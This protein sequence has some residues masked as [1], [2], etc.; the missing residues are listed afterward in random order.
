MPPRL[1]ADTVRRRFSRYGFTILDP[2]FIYRNAKQ[3]VRVRDDIT[4]RTEEVSI[5]ALQKRIKRGRVVE[6][7]PFLHALHRTDTLTLT[8]PGR[9]QQSRLDRKIRRFAQTQIPQFLEEDRSIQRL[10]VETADRLKSV[11]SRGRNVSI[12]R[13]DDP[14][15]DRAQLYAFIDTLYKVAELN[16]REEFRK[17]RISVSVNANGM[18]SFMYINDNTIATLQDLIQHIYFGEPLNEIS[19]SSTAVLFSLVDWSTMSVLFFDDNSRVPNPLDGPFVGSRSAGGPRVDEV[20]SEFIAAGGPEAIGDGDGLRP[21]SADG[22]DV[23]N[24]PRRRTRNVGSLWR[25]LNK[26]DIDLSRYGIFTSFDVTNYRYSCF[27]YALQQSGQFTPEEIDLIND[28][29]NTRAFPCDTISEICRLYDCHI[30]VEKVKHS[31]SSKSAHIKT[32]RYGDASA[33]RRVSLLLRDTH[34]M[35]NEPVPVTEYYLA[36]INR[37]ASSPRVNQSRRFECRNLTD[38]SVNYKKDPRTSLN[39]FLDMMFK[40]RLF[41]RFTPSQSFRALNRDKHHDFTQLDYAPK[42]VRDVDTLPP[43]NV[44]YRDA[45]VMSAAPASFDMSNG[46][47]SPSP[48]PS[49]TLV[50]TTN[51]NSFLRGAQHG[52]FSLPHLH[53]SKHKG[54]IGG[55]G[56]KAITKIAFDNLTV[57]RNARS[58]FMFE[59]TTDEVHL[60]HDLLLTHFDVDF[61]AYDTLA[62]LGEALMYSY[63]CYEDVP[64]LAG[65]PAVFIKQCAPKICIQPAYRKPVHVTGSLVQ[66]DRNGSYTATYTEFEGIPKGAPNVIDPERWSEIK[67]NATYYYV[68]IDVHS[69]SCRHCD[70]RFE[71]VTVGE[72][73]I[74]RNML[75]FIEQHYDIDYTFISGYY[76]DSGFNTNIKRLATDLYRLRQQL[77]RNGQRIES[78][79]KTILSSLWGK[80]QPK[81]RITKEVSVTRD[82]LDDFVVYNKDFLSRSTP[83]TDDVTIFSLLNPVTLHYTRPQFSTNVLSHARTT[84]NSIFYRAADN[85]IPIYYS[86]TDSLVLNTA[87]LDKLNR[88]R[89]GPAGHSRYAGG[90]LVGDDLGQFKRERENICTF[91]CLSPKKYIQRTVGDVDTKIVGLRCKNGHDRSPADVEH[92]FAEWYSSSVSDDRDGRPVDLPGHSPDD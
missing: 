46:A 36:N 1:S 73:F 17:K 14:D 81:R 44:F 10:A 11:V 19:D 71:L 84:L 21:G 28:S 5:D 8:T 59:P 42:C 16:Q 47:L 80:A 57:V 65:K 70:D 37:I 79:I 50:F 86:N 30:I 75:E 92:T 6:V 12:T 74:D 33:S 24:L 35:I 31:I 56:P 49:L 22:D 62:K 55:A 78:C 61:Y 89:D 87:D 40:H 66:I 88:L 48:L 29:I 41:R 90:H 4:N 60:L 72:T 58:T 7:D 64:Q 43:P 3:H 53:I 32:A 51:I 85:D 69:V 82:R 52:V 63:H 68:L 27:V 25:Y 18:E 54:S 20:G 38:K 26:T 77:K 9:R 83:V 67:H 15:T 45:M 34:Y 39:K 13:T 91:I 2:N 23:A 76:F